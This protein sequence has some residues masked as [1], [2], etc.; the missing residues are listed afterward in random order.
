MP[1]GLKKTLYTVN[2][3]DYE[4]R[5]RALTYPLMKGWCKKHG[6]EFVEITERKRPD[7]PATI[8]KFQVAE[9]AEKRGDDWAV[10]FDADTLINPEFFDPTENL[11][12]NTVAHNG[13]DYANVRWTYDNYFR[14]DGRNWGSCT[15]CVIAS[16]WTVGDLWQ[17]PDRPKEEVLKNIHITIGE[18]NSGECKTEHLIDDYTLSRNIARY[19]LKAKTLM[20]VCAEIG[21]RTPDGKGVNQYLWH[22][23]NTTNTKKLHQM[24]GMLSTPQGSLAFP[25]GIPGEIVQGPN[26]IPHLRTAVQSEYGNPGTMIGPIGNGWALMTP[27]MAAHQAKEWGL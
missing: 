14:R 25:F 12:K 17:L 24:L 8:E 6:Y 2:I 1:A 13:S 26:G 23:Y 16:D 20:D 18:H 3:G 19:G 5:I 22:I 21:M 9:L 4:P 7:W 15:W 27:E 11:H 10:F